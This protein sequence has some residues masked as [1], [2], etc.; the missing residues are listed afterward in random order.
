MKRIISTLA[1]AILTLSS[2]TA[3]TVLRGPYLQFPTSSSMKV[4]WRTDV[5]TPSR[6][7]YGTSLATV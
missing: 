6:V 3:Q 1:I 7:Y 2:A 5:Q 4:L